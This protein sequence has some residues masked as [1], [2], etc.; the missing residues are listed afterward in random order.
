MIYR[1]NYE[2]P[3]KAGMTCKGLINSLLT[4]YVSSKHS[5]S[6]VMS[7]LIGHRKIL[8]LLFFDL[9][10]INNINLNGQ[11]LQKRQTDINNE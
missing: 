10:T 6:H 5:H 9:Q 3:A 4:D 1:Y 8:L 11:T 2:I 7:N